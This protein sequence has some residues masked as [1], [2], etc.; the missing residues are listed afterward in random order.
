[1]K[2]TF[3]YTIRHLLNPEITINQAIFVILGIIIF[4]GVSGGF[5]ILIVFTHLF[6]R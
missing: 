5:V 4:G 1:M 3:N 6:Y 2:R